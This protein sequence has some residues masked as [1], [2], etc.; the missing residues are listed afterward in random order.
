M[1]ETEK[2]SV[3]DPAAKTLCIDINPRYK[4]HMSLT[5]IDDE[6]YGVRWEGSP[7]LIGHIMWSGGSGRHVLSPRLC[8]SLDVCGTTAT[9]SSALS[10]TMEGIGRDISKKVKPYVNLTKRGMPKYVPPA[11]WE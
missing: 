11:E 2:K 6:L 9:R 1:T 7:N 5:V 3:Y 10:D 4:V 8:R